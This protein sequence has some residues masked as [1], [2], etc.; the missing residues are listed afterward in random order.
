MVLETIVLPTKLFSFVHFFIE[1]KYRFILIFYVWFYISILCY[2]YKEYL[3]LFLINILIFSTNIP[4]FYYFILTNI[5]EVF[6]IYFKVIEFF[7]LQ[8]TFIYFIYHFFMF[9]IPALYK[10]EFYTYKNY[11][12]ILFICWVS[13][14]LF[15]TFLIFPLTW[16]F[17]ESFQFL[18]TTQ[19]FS[20]E[21]K[22]YEFIIFFIEIYF[23]MQ[24][25]FLSSVFTFFLFKNIYNKYYVKKF[26]KFYYF[27]FI[28]LILSLIEEITTQLMLWLVFCFFYE[29]F[30]FINLFTNKNYK[31]KLIV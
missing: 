17:F 2:Y 1:I 19:N 12:F 31:I 9:L 26:R 25:Y 3:Y 28:L 6:K 22:I 15:I 8:V 14:I 21:V 27:L 29:L 10:K 11:I 24:F 18:L 30:L 20:F 7:N 5:T 4:I 23:L 16:S 13:N